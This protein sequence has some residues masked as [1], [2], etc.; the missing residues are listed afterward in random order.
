MEVYYNIDATGNDEECEFVCECVCSDEM[1]SDDNVYYWKVKFQG[2]RA[3]YS[4]PG[5]QYAVASIYVRRQIAFKN[6]QRSFFFVTITFRKRN[7]VNELLHIII[8]CTFVKHFRYRLGR[9]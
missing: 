1:C 3:R 9:S 6:T 8:V 2:S 4:D 7:P 5:S